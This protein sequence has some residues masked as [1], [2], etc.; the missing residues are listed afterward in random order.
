MQKASPT[1]SFQSY[2]KIVFLGKR[3]ID[4]SLLIQKLLGSASNSEH[5][6]KGI[7][8][9]NLELEF[10]NKVHYIQFW[11]LSSNFD[12]KIDL[13]LRNTS[14]VIFV[15]D[16]KDKMSQK[17]VTN[18]HELVTNFLSV[19]VIFVGITNKEGKV[20]AS[21]EFTNWNKEK[22]F[23]VHKINFQTNEGISLLLQMIIQQIDHEKN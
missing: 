19:K 18:L 3:G 6:S 12:E 13:F 14:L 8:Y 11:D 2:H 17:Y 7:E 1:S 5:E 9:H 4:K 23:P 16:F 10:Q 15:F 22:E 21:K 20:K